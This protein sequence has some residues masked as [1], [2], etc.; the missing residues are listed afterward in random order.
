VLVLTWGFADWKTLFELTSIALLFHIVLRTKSEMIRNSRTVTWLLV[1]LGSAMGLAVSGYYG[2]FYWL[3]PAII[4]LIIFDF[5]ELVKPEAISRLINVLAGFVLVF[6]II[7]ISPRLALDNFQT[8]ALLA[9]IMLLRSF[10][11][12]INKRIYVPLRFSINS[13]ILFSIITTIVLCFVYLSL[14]VK[15]DFFYPNMGNRLIPDLGTL[16][17]YALPLF[18]VV[19]VLLVSQVASRA[20][21]KL[22]VICLTTFLL[23]PLLVAITFALLSEI[24][25]D[26]RLWPRAIYS[27]NT[28]WTTYLVLITGILI[29]SEP[30]QTRL[31]RLLVLV[32]PVGFTTALYLIACPVLIA[33][34]AIT[35]VKQYEILPREGNGAWL[36]QM[37]CQQFDP[38]RELEN[39]ELTE[40]L[41]NYCKK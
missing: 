4:T 17:V 29:Y 31:D 2:M 22:L 36:S 37:T 27:F 26:I 10:A 6:A 30:I 40:F 19:P 25:G 11:I 16:S 18:L 32:K 41:H 20:D 33:V 12:L 9:L 39:S 38:L 14:N 15:D 28:I 23:S 21:L 7:E 5:K 13:L 34:S 3:I 35:A 8:V 1:L 24:D